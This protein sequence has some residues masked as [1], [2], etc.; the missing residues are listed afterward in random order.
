MQFRLL[1]LLTL[2]PF[3]AAAA[4]APTVSLTIH[5]RA[6]EPSELS[7]PAGQKIEL[8]LRNE[9]A[10]ASEFESAELHRE[11]MVP[12]GQEVVVYLGPLPAGRYEF[13]DDLNPKAR[14]HVV[15][16]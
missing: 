13:F 8:H 9:D 11:K 16:K 10:A 4:D 14:G 7:V 5:N 1:L 6:F 3:A 12:A 15:A 2:L